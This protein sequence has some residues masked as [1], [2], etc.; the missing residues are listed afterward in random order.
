M[1]WICCASNTS[2]HNQ[3]GGEQEVGLV[4]SPHHPEHPQRAGILEGGGCLVGQCA[5]SRGIAMSSCLD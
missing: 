5:E 4:D 3:K 2:K 1:F